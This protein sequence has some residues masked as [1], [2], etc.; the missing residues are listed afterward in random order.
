M[1]K[2]QNVKDKKL[3]LKKQT[4]VRLA[5]EKLP[6]VVGGSCTSSLCGGTVKRT[7]IIDTN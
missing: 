1:K 2:N 6:T 3:T 4:I 5:Q 7:C